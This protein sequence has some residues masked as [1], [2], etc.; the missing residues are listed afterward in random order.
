MDT[1]AHPPQ[2][3]I[4]EAINGAWYHRRCAVCHAPVGYEWQPLPGDAD[5]AWADPSLFRTRCADCVLA[6]AEALDGPPEEGV[7]RATLRRSLRARYRRIRQVWIMGGLGEA[8]EAAF[9]TPQQQ[10]QKR[11]QV[12]RVLRLVEGRNPIL[13]MSR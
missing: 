3:T 13:A 9:Y 7:Q 5:A 10:A 8:D 12:Q 6:A 11:Q 2:P 1:V 4:T